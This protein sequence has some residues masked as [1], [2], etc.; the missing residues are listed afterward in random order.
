[1]FER[2]LKTMDDI[3]LDGKRVLVRADFNV[4][5]G[6]DGKVDST[7]DYRIE[8]AL[9]T[10]E[11]LIQ[12]RCRI[13]LLTHRGRT[14]DTPDK[15]DLA[16]I[17]KRLEELLEAK[18]RTSNSLSGDGLETVVDSLEA[19]GI[20]LL[21]NVRT[22][23][24]ENKPNH[25]FAED[26]AAAADV[27]VGEA[28]SVTHRAHTSVTALPQILP[29]AAGRRTVLEV[30][31]LTKLKQNVARPY[32]AIVSGA[33]IKTKIGFLHTLLAQVDTMC[34]G[35]QIANTFLA[36]Q[37]KIPKSGF[38]PEDVAA[39]QHLL[40]E[41][42]AKK[43]ILLDDVTIGHADGTAAKQVS[44]DEIP[45]Q[46]EGIWDIGPKTAANWLIA[47]SQAKT[48][49]WNGPVGKFEEEAYA[50]STNALAQEIAKMDAFRIVGGGDTV[51]ALEQ[52][53]L[54]DNYD[55]VSVGGGAMVAFLEGA[56]MPGL[57]PLYV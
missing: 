56:A 19:G 54:L 43:L 48:I 36:A 31:Q 11:E 42:K 22:D 28:F 45:E 51:N 53:N 39:A 23:D 41:E 1:M 15:M 5:V 25:K 49:M 29:A 33:K 8:A 14:G 10:I 47:A 55:H 27:Y 16:P 46:V 18:V 38:D 44:V 7:E 6:D 35:G 26:L 20:V 40:Q 3:P 50:K 12:K 52:L 9:P 24:R 32:M 21:P 2:P 30:E 17:H 34:V 13:M 37:G 4:S 57:E